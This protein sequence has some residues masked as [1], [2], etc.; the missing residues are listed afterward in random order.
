MIDEIAEDN[1]RGRL[2]CEVME[3]GEGLL[4]HATELAQAL[5]VR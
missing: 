2:R 5:D 1:L 3:Q 4:D